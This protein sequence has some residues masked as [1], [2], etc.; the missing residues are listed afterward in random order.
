M[1]VA[2]RVIPC[3]DVDAGRVVK[4]VRFENLRDEV[5]LVRALTELK[6]RNPRLHRAAVKLNDGFSGEGN[7]VFSFEGCPREEGLEAWIRV[8]F[9]ARISF[10]APA[11][12]W[13]RYRAKFKAM[14]G[15]VECF[16]EGREKR[17][18]SVQCRINPLG[19]V[20]A[21]STHDQLLGGLDGQ[22]F[23]GCTFPAA[24]AYRLAIQEAGLRVAEVWVGPG[25]F[26]Q[27]V[28]GEA[29]F[30]D[31]ERSHMADVRQLVLAFYALVFGAAGGAVIGALLHVGRARHAASLPQVEAFAAECFDVL[32]DN[33][34]S[35]VYGKLHDGVEARIEGGS[36]YVKGEEVV[37]GT[38]LS[39]DD[40]AAMMEEA[41]GGLSTQLQSFT[42][43]TTEFLRREQ[44][45][46][47][48]GEGA[49]ELRASEH[50]RAW[51]RVMSEHYE[52]LRKR[53]FLADVYALYEAKLR[54]P[55]LADSAAVDGVNS[56]RVFTTYF[57]ALPESSVA[58][59]QQVQWSFGQSWPSLIFLPYMSF[60]DG[61]QRQ[62]LGL[63]G[64]SDFVNQ[65]G[66][67]EFAHQWW[68]HQLE[69]AFAE[70][71]PIIGEGLAVYSAMMVVE[72]TYGRDRLRQHLLIAGAGGNPRIDVRFLM[73]A[74]IDQHG[75][76]GGISFP[77]GLV[78]FIRRVPTL[79]PETPESNTLPRS[80]SLSRNASSAAL[81]REMSCTMRTIYCGSPALFRTIETD[82]LLQIVVPLLRMYRFSAE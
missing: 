54:T 5:D 8:S 38:A 57:G 26:A 39:Q 16:I 15:I 56:A 46:L 52:D 64:A 12:N 58:I 3:L 59:T 62:A 51:A 28:A 13:E 55:R 37:S 9:P 65:I 69:P 1:S 43:N 22:V 2:V 10:V 4:G 78:H 82:V 61:T 23:L 11:E 80:S 17:S 47:L 18:P 14:G 50:Y 25:T 29:V 44:D 42:H 24:D 34:G 41:R 19:Q 30:T 35:D 74:K 77:D 72:A 7:A 70:G 75:A 79:T 67:H 45:L 40:I 33:V 71:A 49:P 68:G 73:D 27:D 20:K 63:H 48:H 81:R 36:L 76:G 32:V 31:R 6:R 60:L 21:I 53:N 66:F